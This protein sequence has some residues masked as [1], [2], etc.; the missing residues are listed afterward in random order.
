MD[1]CLR[2]LNSKDWEIPENEFEEVKANMAASS[3][4]IIAAALESVGYKA[5]SQILAQLGEFFTSFGFLIFLLVGFTA[6]IYYAIRESVHRLVWV[7]IGPILFFAMLNVRTTAGGSEWQLGD[8]KGDP[9]QVE[10]IVGET[11]EADVSWFFHLY[12]RIISGIVRSSVRIFSDGT[13]R[14][15]V[16]FMNRE[17]LM[18]RVLETDLM[19]PGLSAVV[20][21]GLIGQCALWLDA[22]RRK[23]LA[24]RDPSYRGSPEDRIASTEYLR[25]KS[26]HFQT[27]ESS[28]PAYSYLMELLPAMR[29]IQVVGPAGTLVASSP[30]EFIG[31][32]CGAEPGLRDDFTKDPAVV[33]AAPVTCEQIWCWSVMGL[34]QEATHT[35]Y[36][37]AKETVD[38]V[39]AAA[40]L[41]EEDRAR[42]ARELLS[43]IALKLTSPELR[44]PPRKGEF[45]ETPNISVVPVMIAGKMLQREMA[46]IKN[47]PNL[48]QIASEAGLYVRQF[49]FSPS[50]PKGDGFNRAT[51]LMLQ[52]QVAKSQESI[53]FT[54]AMLLPYIQGILLYVMA[55]VFPFYCFL[56][57]IP[58]YSGTFF[59]WMWM[60]AWLKSWD[61]GWA[62][63]MNVDE[64]IWDLMPHSGAY[65][66]LTHPTHGPITMMDAAFY[67]DPS[68]SMAMYY[69]LISSVIVGIPALTG[70]LILGR[71]WA[72]FHMFFDGLNKFA[73]KVGDAAS[74]AVA[75][76]QTFDA[77]WMRTWADVE[78]AHAAW[79]D[80]AAGKTNIPAFEALN[81][82]A[83][84][85]ASF[86][87]RVKALGATAGVGGL[88]AGGASGG[89]VALAG[90]S[91]TQLGAQNERM[92]NNFEHRAR[93]LGTHVALYSA[94]WNHEKRLA[95]QMRGAVTGRIQNSYVNDAPDVVEMGY[96]S[97]A[98]MRQQIAF[99]DG[100]MIGTAARV[101]ALPAKG[102]EATLFDDSAQRAL[103]EKKDP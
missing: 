59:S 36:Q 12:N 81:Q 79:R 11:I 82:Q 6:L 54:V 95:N 32:Y 25:L 39:P 34:Q 78:M 46:K 94:N 101:F 70:K 99:L 17:R 30:D 49:N 28:S 26:G 9:R 48:S 45:R 24:N 2:S 97:P 76:D 20:R 47:A 13:I 43:D 50:M 71:E 66:V 85:R 61:L 88:L 27:I 15:Q 92:A 68:Y 69:I 21:H 8:F 98:W 67:N 83:A 51:E 73:A 56:L 5:Q 65:N 90:L 57:L 33:L 40:S 14:S 102:F 41:T 72:L 16:K 55:M 22:S 19:S 87:A 84:A 42:Y 29:K 58:K 44:T 103:Y 80:Q 86:G 100:Q 4:I 75:I 10:K 38:S 1:K 89:L 74:D 35:M 77:D 91:L 3:G 96:V 93:V 62:L 37:T 60:W 18:E 63:A 53:V 7:L 23:A 64:L 31:T 52:H